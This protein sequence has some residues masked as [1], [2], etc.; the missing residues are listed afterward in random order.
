MR[1]LSRLEANKEVRRVLNRHQVD[2]TYTQYSVAG[3]DISLTGWL[4]KTDGS[5]YNA[6]QIEGIVQEFQRILNGFSVSGDFENWNFST[7]HITQVSKDNNESND[8]DS[9]FHYEEENDQ[10]GSG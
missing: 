7:D 8:A 5:N 3:H 1:K 4:C 6:T 2:L 10:E 9:Y